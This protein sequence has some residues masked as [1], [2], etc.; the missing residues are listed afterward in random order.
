MILNQGNILAEVLPSMKQFHTF[1]NLS[2][3]GEP[4]F[5]QEEI[6][7]SIPW[8]SQSSNAIFCLWTIGT[9]TK[10][11]LYF[12]QEHEEGALPK[13]KVEWT[14]ILNPNLKVYG[15]RLNMKKTIDKLPCQ[16]SSTVPKT[17]HFSSG[18]TSSHKDDINLPIAI[19]KGARSCTAHPVSN[20]IS[21]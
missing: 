6:P 8:P 18:K 9:V 13:D 12:D 15:R 21:Y 20:F 14:N 1:L 3:L 11:K 7:L 19:Q 2:Y 16:S 4:I 10:E 5:D 17:D